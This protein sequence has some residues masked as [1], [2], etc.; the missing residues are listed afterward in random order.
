MIIEVFFEGLLFWSNFSTI[1]PPLG[2]FMEAERDYQLLE[3][4]KRGIN[5]IVAANRSTVLETLASITTSSNIPSWPIFDYT[6][7]RLKYY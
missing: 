5:L 6:E 2:T 4:L 1:F 7:H 3:A